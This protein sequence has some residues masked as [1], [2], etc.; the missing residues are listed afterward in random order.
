[1]I[2]IDYLTDIIQ[3]F[4]FAITFLNFIIDISL[5]DGAAINQATSNVYYGEIDEA[6]GIAEYCVFH[7][8]LMILVTGIFG[9]LPK[10]IIINKCQ[11]GEKKVDK[12]FIQNIDL[13]I[14]LIS[15]ILLIPYASCKTYVTSLG[16]RLG[17]MQN[18]SHSNLSFDLIRIFARSGSDSYH[19]SMFF[20]WINVI[21]ELVILMLQCYKSGRNENE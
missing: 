9:S 1:M 7:S 16:K 4:I 11:D 18:L 6:V 10:K 12:N 2:G 8:C 19:A 14:S 15:A 17:N 21:L 20:S 3:L 13:W 5:M